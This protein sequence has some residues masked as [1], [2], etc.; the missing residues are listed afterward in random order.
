MRSH[1]ASATDMA[2]GL[3][4]PLGT[5][6]T[7]PSSLKSA[8]AILLNS[9]SPMFLVWEDASIQP[10]ADGLLLYN[11]ACSLLTKT[12]PQN[13]L[14]QNDRWTAEWPH[15]RADVEQVL[16]TGQALRRD[17]TLSGGNSDRGWS[18]SAIWD[19]TGQIRGVFATGYPAVLETLAVAEPSPPDRQ[20]LLPFLPTEQISAEAEQSEREALLKG[21][22]ID[23][24]AHQCTEEMLRRREEDWRLI[25]N[26]LPALIAY[27]DKDHYYRFN[28][29]TY[30]AWFEQP[31]ASF[32]GRHIREVL[33]EVAYEIV[34][35][36]MEQA[37]SGQ[38][39]TF[40][41]QIPYRTGGVRYIRAD[42]VPH[43]NTQGEVE[44]YFSLITDISERKRIENERQQ[45]EIERERLL[46]E[47][48]AER[49]R[50]E[51]VLRQM[52]EGVI[53]ADAASGEMILA[54][55]RTNQIFQYAYELNLELTEYDQRVPFRA[56]HPNGQIYAPED[57]PLIRSLRTGEVITHEEME[58]RFPDGNAIVIDASSS[59][60]FDPQGQITSAIVVIQD[61]T[62]R[63]R[64]EIALR[65]SQERAQ[66]AIKVGRLGTW[67]YSLRTDQ[68]EL[69]ERMHEIWGKT[70]K[71][72]TISLEEV[73]ARIHPDDRNQVASAIT[74]ALN[75]NSS[76]TYE[77]DYRLVWAD[78]TERW[79]SANGQVDFES[80]GESR[81]A[82]AFFGTALDITD[83]KQA[84]A[85]LR[86]SA[87]QLRLL[88]HSLPVLISYVDHQQRYRFANQTYTDWFGLLPEDIV[89]KPVEEVL[90]QAAYQSLQADIDHVLSGQRL[91]FEKHLLLKTAG[92]RYIQ[93]HFVPDIDE[94]GSIKGYYAL[95][96][97]VTEHRQAEAALRQSE[98]QLRLAQR[99]A[100]AGLW[101]WDILTNQVT[102]SEEYYRLYG[103]DTT[104]TPSYKNWLTSIM[105]LDREGVDQAVRAALEEQTN[106]NVEFRILH[107]TQGICWLTAIGQTFYDADGQPT[108]MTGIALNVTPRKQAEAE[109]EQLLLREQATRAAAEIAE[110]RA[111]FLVKANTTLTSSLDYEYTLNSVAQAIV[112]TLADWCAVDILKDDGTLER[113]ATTHVDPA[114]VQWGIELH[115]RYPPNLNAPQGLAQ[116]LRTGRSEYY[117]TVSDE[118]IVRAARDDDH[119][120]ILREI[121]FSSVMLVPLNARGRTLGTISFVAAE[122][123]RSYS[124]EDLSLAEELAWRA[125]IALDNARLYQEAQ[126]ARQ[127]A[128]RAV[129][130]TTRLQ[131]VTAALSESLTPVQVAE[132]IVEQSIAALEADAALMAL[133]SED[134]TMLEVVRMVGYETS[135]EDAA[136]QKFSI[137]SPF[138]LSE[139]V[140]TKQPVWSEPL[141]ERLSR[142]PGLA[143]IYKRFP[144]EAWISL[145]L[146]VEGKAV[147]GLSLSFTKFR[148]LNQDDRDFILA[149][150]RQC[151]QAIVRAQLY[152][153][154]QQARAEAERANRIKDEFLAVLSHELRSPL[155]PILGWAKLLQTRQFDDLVTKRAL[156]TI[157]RN[158]KLQTELIDDLLDVSRIL[159][160]KMMLNVGEVNLA[161]VV[162]A[163]IETVRLSAE[164]KNI[165]L[166]KIV[167]TDLQPL[168]G[169]AGRLQ[170]VM[171]NLLSNAIKFT[172]PDGQIDIRLEQVG[173]HAQIQVKDTG[174]GI[175]PA[176]LPHV[177]EYFRQEDGTTTRKFGGLGLGLAI[178]QYLTELHGGTVKAESAGEG[179]GATFT[180][181]LPSS[182]NAAGETSDQVGA[183]KAEVGMFS[184]N[185]VRI[186]VVDDEA[187][188]R[189]LTF[190]ILQ[191]TGA[192]TQVVASAIEAL[193]V[194]D[195][196]KPDLLIS[197]IGMAEIDGYELMRQVRSLPPE[198]GG[199]IPAIALTAYAGEIDQ[200]QALAAGFQRHLAK[201]IEPAILVQTIVALLK[202]A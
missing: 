29:Q 63:K 12:Q 71:T 60:I 186:L 4:T 15:I 156:E 92:W 130:R 49:T 65:Q 174:K 41:S 122:S 76:G 125:A 111:R 62:D 161:T 189:D 131:A 177:F 172:P 32:T 192:K 163:A 1:F 109:R 50:F 104:V 2:N 81:R 77:I 116:V 179:L 108:R 107:P 35:P 30:E 197:D 21:E 137:H 167:A 126:Q 54:N 159:R 135:P 27:V 45:A 165:T 26:A 198:R 90:G 173:T 100:G 95:M 141:A 185:H 102:W 20:A 158:A 79:V 151:A 17:R 16:A 51:A 88:T 64:A 44:G 162:D 176:F 171:W 142:Y 72:R 78:G 117:P 91:S 132:V 13:S 138:P 85:A 52:P 200:Q 37:F 31:A 144:F 152:A 14:D 55:E 94:Q 143:E 114:K 139:A 23:R 201:P 112:P 70:D 7:W 43:I 113:L 87:N 42:Y 67:R 96:S 183:S 190:T 166:H 187:D 8:F 191:Q 68:V 188:M 73:I 145:P 103:L 150:T 22:A 3:Q 149:L 28:N 123:G 57:Y 33:G 120:R 160:G 84:E 58:I 119:L 99:A 97:D 157:E 121:G 128:E 178:V 154:E 74:N 155:N 89:G 66:L 175:T 202:A 181:L 36:Y 82:I 169:D 133:L 40:E 134:G 10:D 47:L 118:Q 124:P 59:P 115:R 148:L 193:N 86:Q 80:E 11:D 6:E 38:R 170:Q 53:I 182:R 46:E 61:I 101:D 34:R 127:A 168:S 194:L 98:E 93:S 180:V 129:D 39:V 19:E 146:I 110:Q 5:V 48:A 140:Q 147:G 184:L 196:F 105:E 136:Q 164:A 9:S 195:S 199:Q 75:P 25:T 24:T 18:Y 153:A 56:Y 106:L 83:R 69:D